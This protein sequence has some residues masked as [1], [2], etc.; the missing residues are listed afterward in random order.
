MSAALDQLWDK[1][2]DMGIEERSLQIFKEQREIV[3]VLR[4]QGFEKAEAS[5]RAWQEMLDKFDREL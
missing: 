4:K 5:N 3:E 1:E 2:R